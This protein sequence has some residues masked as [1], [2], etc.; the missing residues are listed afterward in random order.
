MYEIIEDSFRVIN[1]RAVAQIKKGC[2][3]SESGSPFP[4]TPAFAGMTL[5]ENRRMY[6]WATA[7]QDTTFGGAKLTKANS[8]EYPL[9]QSQSR[10]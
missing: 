1:Q 9:C 7:H 5:G 10:L 4:W 8:T 3:S 2:H 6:V